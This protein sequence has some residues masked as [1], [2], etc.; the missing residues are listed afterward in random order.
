MPTRLASTFSLPSPDDKD[1]PSFLTDPH[2]KQFGQQYANLYWSRLKA[3]QLRVKEQARRR[4]EERG[5]E[6][7]YNFL[8]LSGSAEKGQGALM[9]EVNRRDEGV[10][11]E[12]GG[13]RWF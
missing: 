11:A 3:L 12:Q 5:L 1:R 13:P 2:D 4:W 8:R 7:T 9:R 6:G 10:A